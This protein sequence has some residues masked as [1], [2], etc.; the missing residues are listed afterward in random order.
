[1]PNIDKYYKNFQYLYRKIF[2]PFF[3]IY[4]EKK[5]KENIFRFRTPGLVEENMN[6]AFASKS[7]EVIKNIIRVVADGLGVGLPNSDFF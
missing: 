4:W 6:K 5:F 2:I 1:V 3:K 7:T